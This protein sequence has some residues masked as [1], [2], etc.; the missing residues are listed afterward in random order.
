M[1]TVPALMPVTMPP[2]TVAF[3]LLALHRPPVT[4]SV[5]VIVAPIHTSAGPLM[6]PAKGSG[7]MVINDVVVAVPQAVVTV[8]EIMSVPA[9][10]PV[11]RPV[12]D[13]VALALSAL[14]TPPGAVALSVIVA[15]SHTLVSPVIVPATGVVPTVTV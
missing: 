11:T 8:Y 1:F 14:H 4:G 7:L 10:T 13:T 3:V 12:D 2:D 5:S 15:P 6:A 9:A